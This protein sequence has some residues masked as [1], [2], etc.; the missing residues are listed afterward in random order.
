M[1]PTHEQHDEQDDGQELEQDLTRRA[2]EPLDGSDDALLRELAGVMSAVDP[3]PPGLVERVKFALALEELHAEVAEIVRT[4]VD[5]VAVRT[6]QTVE[7]SVETITFTAEG[8]RVMVAVWR[9][10][11]G[12]GVRID[13][14]VS[15]AGV[16]EVVAHQETGDLTVTSDETGRF[17]LVGLAHGHLQLVFRMDSRTVVTPAFEV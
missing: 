14:W 13:G 8:L 4:P 10:E 12:G 16:V 1:T 9:D 3:V 2:E 11:V 17:V 6:A 7:A 15:P 5:P